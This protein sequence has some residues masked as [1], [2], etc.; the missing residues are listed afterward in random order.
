MNPGIKLELKKKIKESSPLY[1]YW[2]SNQTDNDDF[3]RLNKVNT[4]EE[5]KDLTELFKKEPYKWEVLYQSILLEINNNEYDFYRRIT[6][7]ESNINNSRTKLE[8]LLAMLDYKESI[9]TIRSL[10]EKEII[11]IRSYQNLENSIKNGFE[12]LINRNSLVRNNK[13][14]L[15]NILFAIFTNPYNIHI[16]KKKQHIYETT[17][18]I[19]Y[20]VK[21][22]LDIFN[23]KK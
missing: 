21:E 5:W 17:G 22:I 16:K 3:L 23:N 15:F 12:T 10:K 8:L 2:N 18:Y 9:Q 13:K 11:S 6:N 7:S 20:K 1:S 4:K 14:R 19:I